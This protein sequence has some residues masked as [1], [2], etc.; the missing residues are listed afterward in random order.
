MEQRPTMTGTSAVHWGGNVVS[1]VSPPAAGGAN[2]GDAPSA[3]GTGVGVLVG[4]KLGGANVDGDPSAVGTGVG[5][6]VRAKCA[7]RMSAAS[8]ELDAHSWSIG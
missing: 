5:V 4:A 3:V 8:P 2:V 7:A 1:Y 6:F